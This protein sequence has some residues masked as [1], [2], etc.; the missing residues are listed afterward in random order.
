MIN[1]AFIQSIQELIDYLEGNTMLTEQQKF[2][3]QAEYTRRK[4][5][6]EANFNEGMANL[7]REFKQRAEVSAGDRLDQLTQEKMKAKPEL[8]YSAA[9]CEVQT[10]NPKLVEQ[11]Q[12]EICR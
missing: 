5:R 1:I 8:E 6:L 9:F 2:D 7:N 11:Y 3:L 4:Q 10:E 12:Q